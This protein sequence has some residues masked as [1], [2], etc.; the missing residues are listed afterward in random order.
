MQ[1]LNH[2][3]FK[4]KPTEEVI[5][6]SQ[7]EAYQKWWEYITCSDHWVAIWKGITN[8]RHFTHINHPLKKW[9]WLHDL[10]FRN[11]SGKRVVY[12]LMVDLRDNGIQQKYMDEIAWLDTVIP[13]TGLADYDPQL[14]QELFKFLGTPDVE[15]KFQLHVPAIST[16]GY[17]H[18][19]IGSLRLRK[20]PR[21]PVERKKVFLYYLSIPRHEH[22]YDLHRLLDVMF[23]NLVEFTRL[24]LGVIAMYVPE[25][26]TKEKSVFFDLK[27]GN[28]GAYHKGGRWPIALGGE[29]TNLDYLSMPFY[30]FE[31]PELAKQTAKIGFRDVYGNWLVAECD[32]QFQLVTITEHITGNRLTEFRMARDSAAIQLFTI[33]TALHLVIHN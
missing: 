31:G 11:D 4:S 18:D 16:R 33:Q 25:I 17:L 22:E 9:C 1:W 10:D 28:W 6:H 15:R 21:V 27:E 19:K 3:P 23:A 24:T 26:T 2:W 8:N 32:R 12:H 13:D 7:P 14:G 20:W 29:P 30:K 5:G